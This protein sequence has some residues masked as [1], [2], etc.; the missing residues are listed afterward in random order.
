[1]RA[2]HIAQRIIGRAMPN[3]SYQKGYRAEKKAQAWLVHLGKCV[4]SMMS[5]GADLVL[6]WLRRE[7]NFSVKCRAKLSDF[8]VRQLV[9][10]CE[11][12]DFCIFSEDRGIQYVLGPLPKFIEFCGKA[13]AE[14]F[15]NQYL[16]NG[17]EGA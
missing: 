6:L 17:T 11:K 4:R 1:M 10:E 13:E 8:T 9:T 14:E 12:N 5:R 16:P 3:P 7:W 2:A 15:E